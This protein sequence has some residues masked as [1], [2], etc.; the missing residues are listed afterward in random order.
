MRRIKTTI[1]TPLK[2]NTIAFPRD[3]PIVVLGMQYNK[4]SGE[5]IVFSD[6]GNDVSELRRFENEEDGLFFMRTHPSP[7]G[8]FDKWI[9]SISD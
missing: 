6:N 5:Y 9:W 2:P 3:L 8:N 4:E 1:D 7:I